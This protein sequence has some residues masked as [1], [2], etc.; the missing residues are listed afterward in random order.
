MPRQD[1]EIYDVIESYSLVYNDQSKFFDDYTLKNKQR[2]LT[3]RISADELFKLWLSSTPLSIR[4]LP[5]KTIAERVKSKPQERK[6]IQ[7]QD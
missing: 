6:K 3:K 5:Q 7:K 2:A 4:F 1:E